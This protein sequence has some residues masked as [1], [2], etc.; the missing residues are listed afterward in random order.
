MEK[1]SKFIVNFVSQNKQSTALTEKKRQNV[2]RK[3]EVKR[4]FGKSW[5]KSEQRN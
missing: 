5:R 4:E 1:L 2:N 3:N